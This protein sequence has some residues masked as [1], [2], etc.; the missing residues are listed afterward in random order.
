MLQIPSSTRERLSLRDKACEPVHWHTSSLLENDEGDEL[1]QQ[2]EESFQWSAESLVANHIKSGGA[3]SRA[4]PKNSSRLSSVENLVNDFMF[5]TPEGSTLQFFSRI[6]RPVQDYNDAMDRRLHLDYLPMIR[7]MAL[8]DNTAFEMVAAS[9]DTTQHSG[10]QT[11]GS[12]EQG[13]IHYLGRLAHREA[14]RQFKEVSSLSV[15]DTVAVL[16]MQNLNYKLE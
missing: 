11:R 5:S 16:W 10:R 8:Y 14:W 9:A 2:D 4:L 15:E 7:V 3:S 6:H 13:Y 1:Q 12:L